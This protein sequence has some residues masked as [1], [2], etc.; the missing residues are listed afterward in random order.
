VAGDRVVTAPEADYTLTNAGPT[1][2]VVVVVIVSNILDGEWPLNS[3][4]AAASWK[5]AAMPQALGGS[6]PS[7]TGFSA[8]ILAA[9][10]EVEMPAQSML[11]L[12]WMFLMPRA[13][14][15]LP[16]GDGTIVTA[17]VEGRI[18]LA[19]S[20]APVARL[21]SGEWIGVPAGVGSLWQARDEALAVIL[22]LSVS[23]QGTTR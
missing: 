2:A 23:Q 13:A 9:D 16:A 14:L 3:S 22:V 11:A 4:A 6:L 15:M 5:V 19:T 7:P 10:V 1:F 17:V 12:G 20:D 21:A 8:R 18:D